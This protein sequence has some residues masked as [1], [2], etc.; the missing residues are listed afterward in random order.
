MNAARGK[1]LAWLCHPVTVT[2]LALLVINDHLLKSA[3]P[4][5]VTGKLSDVAGMVLAPPL[6]AALA[7]LIAPRA[8]FRPVA[9]AS[10]VT[11]GGGFLFVKLWVYGA[12]LAS[13]AWSLLTP[14]LV[15]ADPSDLLALPALWLAWWT[16]RRPLTGVPA[17]RWSRALRLA[18]VLPVAL[19]GVAATSNTE[20]E[21]P[22]AEQ[23]AV[24]DD[25]AIYL[26]YFHDYP[27]KPEAVSTDGGRTWQRI[28]E[29]EPVPWT[30]LVRPAL[31]GQPAPP[32]PSPSVSWPAAAPPCSGSVPVVCYRV[33]PGQLAVQSDTGDASWPESW[34]ID[35]PFRAGLLQ[36]YDVRSLAS[37]MLAVAD[38]PG[39]HVVVVANGLDGF[40]MRDAGGVWTRIGFP[41]YAPAQALTAAEPPLDFTGLS[42]G[43]LIVG[44]SLTAL[45]IW[46]LSRVWGWLFA[47]QAAVAGLLLTDVDSGAVVVSVLAVVAGCVVIACAARNYDRP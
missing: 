34:R 36:R 24:G 46:R 2:A 40:A 42:I 45:L 17:R 47:P 15:R 26:N 44:L 41:G 10:I 30:S 43:I 31:S 8:P 21:T 9:V 23:V 38:V 18:V 35:G 7:G 4:G 28:E 3:W 32:A 5:W 12:Q 39:G 33:V 19:F 16:A 37:T 22:V 14:S 25:G 11:V 13:A 27:E 20:P 1:A 29:P 6:L